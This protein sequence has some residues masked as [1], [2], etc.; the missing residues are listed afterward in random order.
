MGKRLVSP[1]SCAS[2][3]LRPVCC[4]L[5]A[6]ELY[7]GFRVPVAGE[8]GEGTGFFSARPTQGLATGSI[9]H[10]MLCRPAHAPVDVT[11]KQ[12]Q[13]E[14]RQLQTPLVPDSGDSPSRQQAEAT[15][16]SF[17]AMFLDGS[18]SPQAFCPTGGST[19][20]LRFLTATRPCYCLRMHLG[21]RRPSCLMSRRC[22]SCA[23]ACHV[24]NLI[25]M[26]LRRVLYGLGSV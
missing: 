1:G 14:H 9:H 5:D 11:S 4:R 3:A 25:S 26:M 22:E 2:S 8:I 21:C 6:R 18:S 19:C 23:K 10:A 16:I 13:A 15:S 12:H 24:V 17:P 20:M 7:R